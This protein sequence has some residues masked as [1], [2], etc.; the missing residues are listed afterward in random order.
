MGYI[1][2]LLSPFLDSLINYL[3]KYL[4]SKHSVNTNVLAIYTGIIS[5]FTGSLV[6]ILNRFQDIEPRSA[7]I[8]ILSGFLSVFVLVFY[9]K[10]LKFDEASRVSALFQFV[11]VFVLLLSFLF[12]KEEL[13]RPQYIGCLFIF[14]AGFLFSVKKK[15]SGIIRINKAFW[16]MMISSLL[17]ALSTILFKVGA[18]DVSFWN[19]IPYEGFG[20]GL[21]VLILTYNRNNFKLLQKAEK[22]L[23]KR[24]FLYIIVI[25]LIY[26]ASRYSFYYA[27]LL[28]P[29][30][31]VS[32]MQGFQVFFLLIEGIL[33]TILLPGFI[34][35]VIDKKILVLKMVATIFIFIGLYL[36]F[37]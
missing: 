24:V 18:G 29:A 19:A 5:F 36:I 3:D 10:A 26:R 33:L 20:N 15:R 2:A 11:P 37:I 22:K 12:L 28:L 14:I 17:F 13:S 30:S 1:F 32:V 6:Y 4:V 7:I 31:I 35:E 34:K 27:L 9:F 16:Y 25:E 23:D 21:A 8:L